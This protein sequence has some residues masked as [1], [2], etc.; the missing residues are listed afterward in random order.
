M[1]TII[2]LGFGGGLIA[3]LFY[4]AVEMSKIPDVHVSYSTDQCVEVINYDGTNF[5][6]DNLP[7]R[8]N[9]VWVK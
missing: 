4:V 7:S 3:T 6:C 2:S 5:T 9:H 1:N 8:Y